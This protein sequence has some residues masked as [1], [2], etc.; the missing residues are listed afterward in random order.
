MEVVGLCFLFVLVLG[1][2][3]KCGKGNASNK[4]IKVNLI[5]SHMAFFKFLKVQIILLT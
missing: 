5:V 2:L 4:G 3:L 1:F